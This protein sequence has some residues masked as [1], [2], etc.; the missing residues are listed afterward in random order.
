MKGIRREARS[1][2]AIVIQKGGKSL[3]SDEEKAE[4]FKGVYAKVSNATRASGVA[5]P[6]K[7]RGVKRR[8]VVSRLAKLETR[9]SKQKV[10]GYCGLVH[11]P[12]VKSSAFSMAELE[13]GLDALS[14][15]KA[16]G[17]DGVHN[18]M[19]KH[20]DMAIKQE[21]LAVINLSWASGVTP[22]GLA[23][24]YYHSSPQTG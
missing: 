5:R 11:T 7:V 18:E 19:L 8:S 14:D 16:P 20:L 13:A 24:G 1:S 17:D 4:A 10:R 15:N 6:S 12:S 9:R 3:A 21:L 2:E 23:I 22:R